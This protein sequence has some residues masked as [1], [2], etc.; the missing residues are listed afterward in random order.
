MG[1]N[2]LMYALST[3]I[4]LAIRGDSGVT[5]VETAVRIKR[6]TYQEIG[7]YEAIAMQ[8]ID[9]FSFGK[10]VAKKGYKQSF[11]FSKGLISDL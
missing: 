9:D 11:G 5:I 4:L 8:P 3:Y 10:L 6:S 7:G 2:L 1:N